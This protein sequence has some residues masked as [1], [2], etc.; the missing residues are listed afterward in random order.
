MV[1]LF[2]ER[3]QIC[4]TKSFLSWVC[5]SRERIAAFLCNISEKPM[6]LPILTSTGRANDNP[7]VEFNKCCARLSL[8]FNNHIVK[9]NASLHDFFNIYPFPLT[10]RTINN[11][12]SRLQYSKGTLDIFSCTFHYQ[13]TSLRSTPKVPVWR[14]YR[15]IS[16]PVLLGWMKFLNEPQVPVGIINRYLRLS[17]GTGW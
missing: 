14:W 1:Y 2:R 11:I 3:F 6:L 13:K 10:C 16:I 17:I 5:V 12:K 8:V 9:N 4:S 7:G 15:F